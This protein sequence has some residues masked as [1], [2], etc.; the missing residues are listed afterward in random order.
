MREQSAKYKLEC[1]E[2]NGKEFE[3]SPQSGVAL[4]IC[5]L[6]FCS[7]NPTH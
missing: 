3:T 4:N 6:H 5:H 7:I 2:K 1:I